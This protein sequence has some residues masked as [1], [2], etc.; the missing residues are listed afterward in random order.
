MKLS[1]LP[2]SFQLALILFAVAAV[3]SA[4]AGSATWNLNPGTSDWHTATNWTPATVPDGPSDVAT[5]G[6]SNQT[7]ISV[8]AATTVDGIV[9]DSGASNYTITVGAS[10]GSTFALILSGAGVTNNSGVVQ[11][12]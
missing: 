1:L 12:F 9:F 8:M 4:H 3:S 5:F 6:T 10:A 2:G 11:N 7:A